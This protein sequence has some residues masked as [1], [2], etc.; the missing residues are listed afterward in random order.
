MKALFTLVLLGLKLASLPIYGENCDLSDVNAVSV[1]SWDTNARMWHEL[2]GEGSPF[3]LEVVDPVLEKM[4]PPITEETKVIEIGAGN[5]FLT[6]RLARQGARVYAFDSSETAVSIAK[7][8]TSDDLKN[9]AFFTT[10]DI[11]QNS[12][13]S[14]AGTE[15]DM[16]ICN[17]ALMD[18][19][20]IQ[21]VFSEAYKALKQGGVFIITQTHPCFEK[22]V[23]PIF[24]EVLEKD[25]ASVHTY[26]VKVSHY[27][28]PS[29]IRV[30]AVPQLPCE[31]LFFHRSLT[32][33]IQNGLRLGFVVDQFE[34][35]AFPKNPK[36]TEH[37]GWHALTEIPVIVGIRF[38]KV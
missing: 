28:S 38:K 17:M 3:Q 24:H 19:A 29:Y 31:H 22:A 21:P 35:A 9:R 7:N 16:V 15:C 20:N 34:E 27:L 36:I 37:N 18:I 8:Q 32:E 14:D 5:G 30:K 13:P 33:V 23:G 11:T 12:I 6:R 1:H 26:G 4:I 25:G 10:L 2:M